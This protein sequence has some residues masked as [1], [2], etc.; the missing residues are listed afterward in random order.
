VAEGGGLLN[1]YRLVKA[2]R[3]FESLRLRQPRRPVQALQSSPTQWKGRAYK[4]RAQNNEA[5]HG[6]SL[7]TRNR[8]LIDPSAPRPGWRLLTWR[9]TVQ[10]R[11]H[12][13]KLLARRRFPIPDSSASR[14]DT[15]EG[16]ALAAS[17]RNFGADWNRF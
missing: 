5:G 15:G 3:G 8:P 6:N 2:Y 10:F 16:V 9:W 14:G 1:R 4:G 13:R 17:G 12:D 11:G 7:A